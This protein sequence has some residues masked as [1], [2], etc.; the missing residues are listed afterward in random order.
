MYKHSIAVENAREQHLA[1]DGLVLKADDPWWDVHYPPNGW[2]CQCY[3]VTL[4]DAEMQAKGLTP[5]EA[6]P[7]VWGEKVVGVRTNPRTVKVADGVDAG[8]AYNVGKAA[9]GE[10]M[11]QRAYDEAKAKF[12][13]QK[14]WQPMI[15]TTWAEYNRSQ[16]VPLTPYN[17]PEDLDLNMDKSAM[18]EQLIG[19]KEKVFDI[20]GHPVLINAK[21]LADHLKDNRAIY[22]PMMVESLNAPYEV[23]QNF[24]VNTIN[25]SVGLRRRIISAYEYR[26]K[27]IYIVLNVDNGVLTGWTMV[28]VQ[29]KQLNKER[30]GEL[31]KAEE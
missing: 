7:T 19:G 31:I 12:A 10:T 6:P 13:N 9:W 26:G 25:G 30:V 17:P 27:S 4:S 20:A 8:F 1:W 23:W 28:P 5:D 16:D 11:Q 22:L 2:G 24:E 18:L 15:L 21:F 29:P 14:I 3:V